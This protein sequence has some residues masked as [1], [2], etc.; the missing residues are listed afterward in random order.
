MKKIDISCTYLLILLIGFSVAFNPI[1]GDTINEDIQ[2]S[3]TDS[4]SGDE[5]GHSVSIDNGVAAIG[6]PFDDDNGANSGAAY[7]FDVSTGEQIVKLLPLDD[8]A[9]AEFGFSIAINNGIVAV[10]ARADDENGTNAGA[11]YLFDASTGNQLFKLTPN[12]AEPNDEFGNSIAIDNDIVAVG[13]WRADEYGD[14]SG[15]AYLF[16]ATT[17]N[18]LDKLLPPTGNNYQTFGVSIAMDDGLVVIGARTFFDLNDGYTFAKAHLFDVSTGN[19][20]NE[21]QPDILDLNGDQGGHFA[22]AIDIDNGLIAVGAPY[23][24]VVWDFS[25]AA[26]VFNATTGEQ[27]HFI[28]PDEVWDRDHFGISISINNGVVAIGSQEDDDNGFDSGSAYLYDALTGNEISKLLASDGVEFD[29]FGTSVAIDGDV[30]VV[31]AKGYTESHTGSAYVYSGTT[32]GIEGMDSNLSENFAL[33]QN[34]PNPFNPLTIISYEL[35]ED[36][37]VSVTIYDLLGN[38]INNLVSINQ[39][40][41]YKSVQCNATNNLGQPVSAGVYLYSIETKDFRQTKK[42]ILLK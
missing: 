23:R 6:A 4:T 19:Q 39:S 5:F 29:L 27:L 34:Y 15:A 8:V 18:Q 40:S 41:G 33:N 10:G 30:T 12:D 16:D 24:S 13:A 28:F 31:G 38:V 3:A 36:S 32:N 37:Y 26:Y 2:L 11:A 14:G 20:L 22:D 21:F 1:W 7:L 42:M 25:G 9:G 35:L 17:G